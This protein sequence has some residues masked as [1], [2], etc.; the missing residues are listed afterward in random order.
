MSQHDHRRSCCRSGAGC[1]G[2]LRVQL[3]VGVGASEGWKNGGV[4]VY[5]HR[6]TVSEIPCLARVSAFAAQRRDIHGLY[7][8]QVSRAMGN[9]VKQAFAFL[10]RRYRCFS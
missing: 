9:A 8:N 4:M 7:R 3:R 1:F 6:R 2:L 10:R 5:H